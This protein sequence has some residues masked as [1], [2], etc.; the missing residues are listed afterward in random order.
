MRRKSTYNSPENTCDG[1][2]FLVNLQSSSLSLSKKRHGL[3]FLFYVFLVC[4]PNID[5]ID[6]IELVLSSAV[7]LYELQSFYK[8]TISHIFF[9]EFSIV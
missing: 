3:K 6:V 5:K 4:I 2:S 8:K 1:I 7:T 9:Y